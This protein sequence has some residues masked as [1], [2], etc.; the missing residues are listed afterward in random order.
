MFQS[1]LGGRCEG[2]GKVVKGRSR[3]PM[4]HGGRKEIKGL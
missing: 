4:K 1:M 2:A 3:C